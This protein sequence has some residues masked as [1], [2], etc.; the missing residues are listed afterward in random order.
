MGALAQRLSD[1]PVSVATYTGGA[2]FFLAMGKLELLEN[3]TI[4]IHISFVVLLQ[5]RAYALCDMRKSLRYTFA[6]LD[7]V[8][9]VL[10]LIEVKLL[11]SELIAA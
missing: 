11:R 6:I 1:L 5:V 7:V 8:A 3:C 9:F 10:F 2:V 4:H